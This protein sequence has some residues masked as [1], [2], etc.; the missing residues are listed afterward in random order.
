MLAKTHGI[1]VLDLSGTQD[2]RVVRI[3]I[4]YLECSIDGEYG[5]HLAKLIETYWEFAPY[6]RV[7]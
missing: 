5:I 6:G 3:G 2:M 4:I 1:I 7:L